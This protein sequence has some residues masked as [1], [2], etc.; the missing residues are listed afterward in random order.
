MNKKMISKSFYFEAAHKLNNTKNIK[1]KNLHGHSYFVEV[2]LIDLENKSEKLGY[3]LDFNIFNKK[4]DKLKN[5]L[6]HSY[7]ND[8][9]GLKN[10]TLENIGLYVFDKMINQKLNVCKVLVKRE[11]CG[12]SFIL[13][14]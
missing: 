13:E 1:N 8:I 6:D 14:L 10:P 12:E 4:I 11:S 5:I 7:L 2:F 3:V 9:K